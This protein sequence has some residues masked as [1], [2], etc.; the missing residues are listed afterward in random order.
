M[1][2]KFQND[3]EQSLEIRIFIEE[4]VELFHFSSF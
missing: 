3:P 2:I 1:L 4:D